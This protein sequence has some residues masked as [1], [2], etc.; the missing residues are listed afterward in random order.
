VLHFRFESAI[1]QTEND[2]KRLTSI[3]KHVDEVN[4]STGYQ[5]KHIVIDARK[6]P[7]SASKL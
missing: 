1:L 3:Q 5:I 4:Q 7:P 6:S 2:L